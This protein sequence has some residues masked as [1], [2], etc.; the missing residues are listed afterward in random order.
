MTASASKHVVFATSGSLG[1]LYP[2]LALGQELRRRGHRATIATTAN[3]RARVEA[4][5]LGFRRMRPEP[6]ESPDFLA[7]FMHPKKGG[8]FVYRHFL[9]P[10]IA[11]SYADLEK[12]CADADLLVSQSLMALAAPLLAARTGIPWISA[13]FQPMTLFS[14]HDRPNY[15]PYPVLPWLC[16]RDPVIHAKVLHY[17]RKYTEE[18]VRPVMDF[19]RGLGIDDAPHPMYE[20]QHSPDCV[21]AMFSPLLGGPRPD[22][23]KAAVQTGTAQVA[24]PASASSPELDA[25]L[26]RCDRPLAVFTLSSTASDTGTFYAAALEAARSAGMR[27]LLVTSGAAALQASGLPSRLPDWA[28]RVDYAPFERVFPHAAVVVH[29]GGIGTAFKAMQ[30][31]VRQVVV[32]HA[33]DQLDNAMRLQRLGVGRLLRPSQ[34]SKRRLAGVIMEALR[35]ETMR[36]TATRVQAAALAENGAA[37]ACDIIERRLAHA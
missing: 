29:A 2:F 26:A 36:K 14:V 19:R 12:S 21:L 16:G 25:F 34:A 28:L 3:H 31:G 23:P 37:A 9:A 4:A 22:W 5:G 1:D 15:L 6:E 35:D 33:H 10:A 27:A 24:L 30:A 8:E 7:R 13:V 17:V 18:W 20:G 32:P 11:D